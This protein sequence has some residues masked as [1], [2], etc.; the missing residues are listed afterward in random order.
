MDK[1]QK[2]FVTDQPYFP[3]NLYFFI[4]IYYIFEHYSWGQG[5]RGHPYHPHSFHDTPRRPGY[6]D[7]FDTGNVFS[8]RAIWLT[9][10]L[11]TQ[12]KAWAWS[13]TPT[14]CRTRAP[15]IRIK[16]I[17]CFR[18]DVALLICLSEYEDKDS[19][20]EAIVFILSDVNSRCIVDSALPT[21][22][23]RD[24]PDLRVFIINSGHYHIR[25][26]LGINYDFPNQNLH[27]NILNPLVSGKSYEKH[28]FGCSKS[29][30]LVEFPTRIF[31][32]CLCGC[33][34]S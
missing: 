28:L 32:V 6:L 3:E 9:G 33:S 4:N 19:E 15:S 21:L 27:M 10:C 16:R 18:W 7:R 5:A 29:E 30:I 11:T 1:T 2:Y 14:R 25:A 8:I 22:I 20:D 24:C 23:S 31:N 34:C 17:C 12:G 26:W 13:S